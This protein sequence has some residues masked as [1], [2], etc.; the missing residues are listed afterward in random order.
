[1]IFLKSDLFKG[2]PVASPI[3]QK[4]IMG[5]RGGKIKKIS[6][7][8]GKPIYYKPWESQDGYSMEGSSEDS[9]YAIPYKNGGVIGK[10]RKGH[11]IPVQATEENTKVYDYDDHTDAHRAHFALAQYIKTLIARKKGKDA[12][13]LHNLYEAHVNFSRHHNEQALMDLLHRKK[14]ARSEEDLSK[15][16][17]KKKKSK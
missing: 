12:S 5:P 14:K 16:Q 9:P 1:M 3:T 13:K 15:K 8:T 2:M 4:P 17:A 6:P 7:T 11:P 10:T